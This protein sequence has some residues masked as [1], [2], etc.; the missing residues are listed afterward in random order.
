MENRKKKQ[1]IGKELTKLNLISGLGFT[2]IANLIVGYIL[3]AFLDNIFTTGRIFKIIFIVLGTLSGVY[4]G[5]RYILKEMER[6]DK[7]DRDDK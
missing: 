2:I 7:I 5:I 3:G 1:N 6:Y 4:N